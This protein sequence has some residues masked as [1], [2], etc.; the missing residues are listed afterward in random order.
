MSIAFS[1]T[2]NPSAHIRI[3]AINWAGANNNIETKITSRNYGGTCSYKFDVGP[4]QLRLIGGGFYQE[5]EGF[6]E[7]SGVWRQLPGISGLALQSGTGRL[8]L[9]DRPGD[10][11]LASPTRFRNMPACQPR[12]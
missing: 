12:L 7:R 9:E 6:K 10:G 2:P 5:V 1:I 4:G 11:A 3:Q 8:D